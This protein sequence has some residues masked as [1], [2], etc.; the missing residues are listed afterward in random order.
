MNENDVRTIKVPELSLVILI[1]VSGSGKSSFA[2]KHFKSTEVISSDFCRG[3]VSDDE[4]DQ[5]ATNAAFEVLHY[6]AGKRLEAGKLTVIDATN[7]QQSSRKALIELGQR[8]H[9]LLQAIVL[10]VPPE[11]CRERNEARPDRD[12]GDHVLRN[13]LSQLNRSLRGLKREGFHNLAILHGV[14]EINSIRIEREPLLN[15]RKW[16]HGP[17]DVIGDVHGCV[18]EL[19]TLLGKLGYN[20]ADDGAFASHPEGRKAFFVGDLVDRG[21]DSPG[22][23]RLV[24]NMV[25]GGSAL[26]VPGNHEAKLLKALKG[27]QV[28]VTHGLAETLEQLSH[29]SDEFKAEVETFIY[30]LVSHLV[31]DD[32][33]LVVAHAGLRQ[34]MQGRASKVVRSFAMYG[35]TTGETNEYGLPV[36]YPWATEYR[37]SAVVAYGHTPVPEAEWINNTICL[38]TGCVFGGSL[39]AMRYPER[40]LVSVPAARMYYEPV[41]PLVVET[42][43]SLRDPSDL[44]LQDVVGKRQI[45]TEY[46]GSVT[47]REEN[48]IAALEVMSRFAVDPRWL[49]YLPPTM[50]PTATTTEPGLLEHPSE[51]FATFKRDGVERV[52]CEEKHMGSRGVI[53]V[54]RSE[55]TA[56]RRF[57]VAESNDAGAIVTRTGRAFFTDP[58]MQAEVLG[59]VRAAIDAVGLWEELESDWFVIDAEILPWSL[60]AEELL[61]K[62]YASVGASGLATAAAEVNALRSAKASSLDVG[63]LLTAAEQRESSIVGFVDA[64]RRY[65]WTITNIDDVRVAP[66]QILA[67]EGKVHA[68]KRHDW[69]I[70]VIN[71]LCDTDENL[72]RRT[73]NMTVELADESSVAAGIAWWEELTGAGG[74]G[75]VVKPMQVVHRYSKGITQ[76]GIKCRGKEYLRIIYGAEYTN[77][78]NLGRL[79]ERGLGLKRSLAL[80]EFAL[81][82]EALK[83]FVE[84]DPL[85]R[86]H[87]AVFGVLALESQPVDPRL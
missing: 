29:E 83:R 1:G 78:E 46:M 8:H 7:V 72:F 36:R 42:T 5:A 48:A 49:V 25:K 14:D 16:D 58:A 23:L 19:R 33:K 64:Y 6:I 51:A 11:V 86:V 21:P 57:H 59:R 13:Q 47:I 80:R 55:D 15:D 63:D 61:R 18:D 12:F 38:D 24:M 32:G 9:V 77:P 87:E 50:A 81:G 65:C 54:C 53:V 85:Y 3:L 30:D 84:A 20:V 60:K 35:D 45:S 73:R 39:T 75:M 69:H 27:R 62:Q 43:E 37:G 74:E 68:L 79:R 44:D 40:E 67:G 56:A 10:D 17:F 66:F 26:C 52:I 31:V 82:I 41:K 2:A 70:E 28:S 76:P 34:E 4:N 22:V 71:R